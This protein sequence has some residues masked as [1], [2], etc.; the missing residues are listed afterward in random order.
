MCL[1]RILAINKTNIT[2]NHRQLGAVPSSREAAPSAPRAPLEIKGVAK[3]G[4]PEAAPS[5]PWA[6]LEIKGVAKLGAL[7]APPGFDFVLCWLRRFI[8]VNFDLFRCGFRSRL[9]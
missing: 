8:I 9:I 3:L 1:I 7:G 2:Y 5:A 4:S 6:S